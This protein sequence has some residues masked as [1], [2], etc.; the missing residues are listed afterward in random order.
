MLTILLLI[1]RSLVN[2]NDG[3]FSGQDYINTNSLLTFTPF[4]G[5]QTLS[6]TVQIL[7]DSLVEYDETFEVQLSVPLSTTLAQLGNPSKTVVTI[8]DDD[9][10]SS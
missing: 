1:S 5:S 8:L 6:F 2:L 7:P 9:S 4:S 10:K 3:A